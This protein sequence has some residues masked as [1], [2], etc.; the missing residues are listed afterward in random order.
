MT[1]AEHEGKAQ[2]TNA[3]GRVHVALPE[4]SYL[5]SAPEM[6]E[7]FASRL[8]V[9]ASRAKGQ[10]PSALMVVAAALS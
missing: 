4:G 2:V 6:A 10:N 9:E 5:D 7:R 3:A 8:L 1:A